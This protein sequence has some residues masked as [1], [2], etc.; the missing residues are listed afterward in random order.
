MSLL[1]GI[2]NFNGTTLANC[3]MDAAC[4]QALNLQNAAAITRLSVGSLG[5]G[6]TLKLD[7]PCGYDGIN[8]RC[9]GGAVLVE[10]RVTQLHMAGQRATLI[11]NGTIDGMNGQG[12]HVIDL[13]CSNGKGIIHNGDFTGACFALCSQGPVRLESCNL[14][15]AQV[16]IPLTH[17]RNCTIS[18]STHLA[19]ANVQAATT[20]E[21]LCYVGEQGDKHYVRNID[22]LAHLGVEGSRACT[23]SPGAQARE[24]GWVIGKQPPDARTDLVPNLSALGVTSCSMEAAFCPPGTNAGT[25][26]SRG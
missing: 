6:D 18:H 23:L 4:A 15:G 20:L 19:G 13:R 26:A 3:S 16:N 8:I 14:S 9:N 10:S 25:K 17:A 22:E 24:C 1:A 12:M 5:A 11:C 2:T 7:A 21:N